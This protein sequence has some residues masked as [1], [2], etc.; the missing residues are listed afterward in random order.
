MIKKFL[1]CILIFL[2]FILVNTSLRAKE[3]EFKAIFRVNSEYVNITKGTNVELAI[4][5]LPIFIVNNR[6][7]LATQF[8]S[9]HVGIRVNYLYEPTTQSIDIEMYDSKN[10]LLRITIDSKEVFYNG[11]KILT[12]VAPILKKVKGVNEGFIPLRFV[13][14]TFGYTVE[15]NNETREITVYK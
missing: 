11:K 5:P 4:L 12:D 6:S 9:K 15:W 7:L 10:N 8:L 14:E 1:V 2:A 13:F 3:I